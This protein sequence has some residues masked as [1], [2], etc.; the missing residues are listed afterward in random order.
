MF[1]AFGILLLSTIPILLGLRKSRQLVQQREDI[2]GLLFLVNQCRQDI[3]YQQ[4]PLAELISRLPRQR[5]K[6]VDCLIKHMQHEPTPLSAWNKTK[7][8]LTHQPSLSVM[9][10]FFS[11]LGTSDRDSQIKICNMIAARLEELRLALESEASTKAKLYR[12]VG[13]LAGVFIA[14]LLI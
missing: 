3:A 13:I 9:N 12:T 6:I 14:I 7:Q 11:A 4:L 8:I 1:K 5:Y 10:D 2:A